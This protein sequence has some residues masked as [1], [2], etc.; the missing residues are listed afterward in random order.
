MKTRISLILFWFIIAILEIGVK[1][2]F[3]YCWF[4]N[5]DRAVQIVL[6]YDRVGNVAMG[7]G[8]ETVSSW[9]GRHNSWLEPHINKLF[10]WLNGEHN[11]CDNNNRE[12]N[13]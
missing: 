3:I 12:P 9:A 13:K 8:N 6:G 4:F 1:L 5:V 11:H 10:F 7:Q 2:F